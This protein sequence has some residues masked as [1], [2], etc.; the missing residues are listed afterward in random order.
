MERNKKT[1]RVE[2]AYILFS[3]HKQKLSIISHSCRTY[4]NQVGG[5]LQKVGVKILHDFVSGYFGVEGPVEI[6]KEFDSADSRHLQQIGDS[7]FLSGFVFF[8]EESFKESS[9]LFGE[10][11]QILKETK[12]FP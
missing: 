9:F 10:A 12:M 2:Q 11:F 4:E 7:F 8:R 5:F 6:A 3:L 1:F